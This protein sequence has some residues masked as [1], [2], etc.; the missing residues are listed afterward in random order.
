M[1]SRQKWGPASGTRRLRMA[2]CR[3]VRVVARVRDRAVVYRGR[4]P[5]LLVMLAL[6]AAAFTTGLLTRHILAGTG[7]VAILL[8]AW[9]VYALTVTRLRPAGSGGDG[10]PPP[11]GAGVREPRRPRPLSPSGA[12]AAPIDYDEPPGR[13]VA[14]V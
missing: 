7:T 8:A 3:R 11:G 2:R 5:V 10:P 1:K 4:G 6:V 14:V 13:T 12:A 9:L